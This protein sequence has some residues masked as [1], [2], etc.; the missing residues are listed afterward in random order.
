MSDNRLPT[1]VELLYEVM[2]CNAMRSAQEPTAS[3]HPC[4]YFRKWGTYHS[5]DYRDDGPPPQPGVEQASVYVGR[6]SLVPEVLSGCRKAPI[7]AVGIN[8]NLPGWWPS[9]HRSLNPLFDDY[10]QFAHYFRYRAVSKL[11]LREADYEQFGGGFHDRPLKRVGGTIVSSDFDLDVPR[12]AEGLRSI[13]VQLQPQKMYEAYQALLGSLADEMGWSNNALM[14]GEDLAYGNMV[15]CPSARWTTRPNPDPL[16]PI[17]SR[18]ERGGIVS[19]C[20]RERRYFLRQLFQSLPAV[21]LIFSQ[22]TAN[23]FIG[24]LQGRFVE[25]DPEP[26]N[27]LE[28][29]MQRTV[30]LHY[31]DLPDGTALTAQIIFAPH[32]TGNPQDFVPARKRVVEQL[33]ENAEAGNLRYNPATKHLHRPRGSC[34]LC[35]ILEIGDCGYLDELAPLCDAPKL[36]A[37]SPANMLLGEKKT[38]LALLEAVPASTAEIDIV[39]DA[40]DEDPA[41]EEDL[42]ATAVHEAVL[43][44]DEVDEDIGPTYLLQGRIVTMNENGDVLEKGLLAIS[45]GLIRAVLDEGDPIPQDFINAPVAETNGT[46]YPGLI[47]L[48]SHFVYNVLPLWVV[49]KK[50]YNR[51]QWPRHREYKSGV[52]KPIRQALARFSVTAEAIVRFVEAKALL[53]GTTTGQGMRTRVRGGSRLFRGAMRNVEETKDVRLP[54]ARTR[55]PDLTITGKSGPENIREFRNALEDTLERGAAYFYHLSEGVDHIARRH[56]R[57]LLVNDLIAP[58]L[59]G[60]HSLGLAPEDLIIMADN[61]AKLVWSPFSN[62]LLYGQTLDLKAVKEAGVKLSLGCDWGPSGSKNLLQELKIASFVNKEQNSPFAAKELVG[63]VTA[64]AAELIGWEKYLGRL[65]AGM[66]A[67]VLVVAGADGNPYEGLINSIEKDVQL[68]TVHGTARYG[69]SNLMQK[70][71][72]GTSSDLE[73]FAVNGVDKVLYLYAPASPLN[74][75]SLSKAIDI[76]RD[77]MADLPGFVEQQEAAEARLHSM[78]IVQPQRFAIELDNE[79]NLFDDPLLEIDD[80]NVEAQLLADIDMVESLPLEDIIVNRDERDYW[81]RVMEE[82]N[83][84]DELKAFLKDV[85]QL[86]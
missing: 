63:M 36:T 38:Q 78:G 33:V 45:R 57:N 76:L 58:S 55:V 30:R 23:A 56:F 77:A 82:P 21:L 34:V 9:R 61:Q 11:E 14:V 42:V 44:A 8:P 62:L 40:T 5:Y 80:D 1:E 24:E 49:P 29:L 65:Q 4:A 2:P 16:L 60:I 20:F 26:G 84:S 74:Q 48:H 13:R 3:P 53:G 17:M 28:D 54:E 67:D 68:V 39:W 12:D 59:V 52:S 71:H 35:P 64:D 72:T 46:M 32:I 69:D 37:D 41:D 22:S 75:L 66:L 15:A 6:A 31:G 47:D 51:S 83:L 70:L 86:P 73:E 79:F 85:Y 10:K 18:A 25:G 50:Y 27:R 7:M 81:Q 43:F 19:A